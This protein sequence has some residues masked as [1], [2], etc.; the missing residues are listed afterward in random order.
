M[1]EHS[2]DTVAWTDSLEVAGSSRNGHVR[3]LFSINTFRRNA[4]ADRVAANN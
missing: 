3:L 2:P 1:I 4:Q